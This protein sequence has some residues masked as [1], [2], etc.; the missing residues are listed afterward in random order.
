VEDQQRTV[1]DIEI[2]GLAETLGISIMDL[3]EE[4]EENPSPRHTI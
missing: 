4:A 3:F 1:T 2:A